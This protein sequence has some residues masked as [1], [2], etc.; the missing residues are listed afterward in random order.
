MRGKPQS[1]T[2]DLP[3]LCV[4]A[5]VNSIDDEAR[6]AD[7]IFSTGAA[8]E[9]MDW[10]TGKKYIER[11]GMKPENLR[12]ERLNSG[13][14]LLDAHS[15]YSITDQIG[16]V[17][18]DTARIEKGKGVA[19]V[20]FSRREAVESIWSDV[21]DRILRSVSV[22]YRILRF[23]ETP[24]VDGG[25]TTRL[26]TL[27]EPFEVSLVPMPADV[28]AKVRAGDKSNTNQCVIVRMA[29]DEDR[30]RRFRLAAARGERSRTC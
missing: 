27:W 4:R 5:E 19:T 16:V 30:I 22:G 8:V 2:I 7:L 14:P 12:L 6:T 23:E 11:L 10:W 29:Q 18:P 1:Q 20:R 24:G 21:K 9:R 25:L 26:A 13:A 17:E 3:P 15:S 28:G